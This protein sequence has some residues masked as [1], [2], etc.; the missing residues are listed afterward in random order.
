MASG[1]YFVPGDYGQPGDK[2]VYLFPDRR[3]FRMA[4]RTIF[5]KYLLK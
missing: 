5:Q 4:G 1:R 2:L 3:S